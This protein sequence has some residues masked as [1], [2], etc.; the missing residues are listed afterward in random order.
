VRVDASQLTE[1]FIAVLTVL[2]ALFHILWVLERETQGSFYGVVETDG[3][4]R[5]ED[6]LEA[7][8]KIRLLLH[9]PV[10]PRGIAFTRE[11]EAATREFEALVAAWDG[12]GAPPDAMVAWAKSFLAKWDV[13]EG[14]E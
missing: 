12:E 10:T 9:P 14:S 8:A 7:L 2:A 4:L 6:V 3:I 1:P 11:F 5:K 13:G